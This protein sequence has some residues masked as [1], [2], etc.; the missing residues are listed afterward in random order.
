MTL[1][2]KPPVG[3]ALRGVPGAALRG[4]SGATRQCVPSA[5]AYGLAILLAVSWA[6]ARWA[7]PSSADE[8]PADDFRQVYRQDAEK[9]A[10]HRD[11]E[12]RHELT[13]HPQPVMRWS[14]DDDWSGEVFVWTDAGRPGVI[15]CILSGPSG[16]ENRNVF[17]EF[18]LLSE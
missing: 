6:V 9:Y 8:G 7:A 13:L 16:E 1:K 2:V 10:F 12:R 11:E 5:T 18:H 4:V 17:H 14:N 3:N 15:G